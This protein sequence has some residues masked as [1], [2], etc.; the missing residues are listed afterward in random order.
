MS[1]CGTNARWR[2]H[3]AECHRGEVLKEEPLRRHL[4]LGFIEE[5]NERLVVRTA[6][7]RVVRDTR[8]MIWGVNQQ[9]SI[10]MVGCHIEQARG[11]RACHPHTSACIASAIAALSVFKEGCCAP[12]VCASRSGSDVLPTEIRNEQTGRMTEDITVS[13]RYYRPP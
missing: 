2:H 7:G 3:E 6:N 4:R 9:R 13:E 5:S 12:R 8:R 11:G 1:H 10:M